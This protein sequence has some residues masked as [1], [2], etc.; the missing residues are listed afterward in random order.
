MGVWV[1]C[2]EGH[3]WF[4]VCN[5]LSPKE[6]KVVAMRHNNQWMHPP[7]VIMSP[8]CVWHFYIAPHLSVTVLLLTVHVGGKLVHTAFKDPKTCTD[9]R[10]QKRFKC[11]LM[12]KN[13]LKFYL[14]LEDKFQMSI[15]P[16][17]LSQ[18]GHSSSTLFQEAVKTKLKE[19]AGPF[20]MQL[21]SAG[22]NWPSAHS[23]SQSQTQNQLGG[24]VKTW[25]KK[26]SKSSGDKINI[27]WPGSLWF[28]QIIIDQ[29]WQTT[30]ELF[31][32]TCCSDY[33]NDSIHLLLWV[34]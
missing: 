19:N 28:P 5:S 30:S 13:L 18:N 29:H 12:H 25:H 17:S 9:F 24:R 3:Q 11:L 33:Q 14:T 34:H 6:D 10:S 15:F 8:Q 21:Y 26:G 32:H 7:A 22:S 27:Q 16:A 2:G 20:F 31:K 1:R 23:V 4:C